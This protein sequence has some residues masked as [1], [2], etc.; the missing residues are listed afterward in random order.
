MLLQNERIFLKVAT[1]AGFGCLLALDT[2]Y[3]IV[4]YCAH[5]NKI[6]HFF[7][8]SSLHPFPYHLA[9]HWRK[10][11]LLVSAKPYSRRGIH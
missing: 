4:V 7:K 5:N 10:A 6:S 3:T 11:S 9:H 1:I 2:S 8:Y